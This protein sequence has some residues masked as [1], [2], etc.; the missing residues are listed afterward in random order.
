MLEGEILAGEF[1]R[2]DDASVKASLIEATSTP[3]S[4][5]IRANFT[6]DSAH[7]PPDRLVLSLYIELME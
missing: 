7:R 5:A 6:D 4:W 1:P 2:V 3:L